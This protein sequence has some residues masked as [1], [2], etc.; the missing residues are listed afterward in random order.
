MTTSF[1]AVKRRSPNAPAGKQR[2]YWVEVQLVDEANVAVAG[3][4]W[5]LESHHPYDGHIEEFT[6]TGVSDTTGLIRVDMPY[7]LPLRLKLAAQPLADEMEKRALRPGRDAQEHSLV[8]Q[9][10]E[11]AG[12]VWHYAVIG[13]LCDDYPNIEKRDGEPFPPL[14]HFPAETALKGIDIQ[15]RDLEK[16]HVIEICPFRAWELVLHHQKGYSIANA[17]NLGGAACLAYADNNT[18]D[19]KS[20]PQFFINQC[21]DLSA[22]PV[23]YKSNYKNN[24]LVHDVPFSQRY[25]VP[26]FLDTGNAAE[27]EGDTRLFYV[28]NQQSIIVSWRGTASGTDGITDGTFRPIKSESCDTKMQC[29]DLLPA[30]KVHEGFWEAYSLAIRKFNDKID[31]V[32]QL[33]LDKDLFIAGHSLGGA[34]ALI[35]A[36]ELKAHNPLL[37]TYGMP[38]TFTR[39]ALLQLADIIH[40]RHV[41]DTD[42]VPGV[43]PEANVDN[44]FYDLWGPIGSTLGALWSTVE[45]SAYQ[46]VKWG[47]CYWHHGSPVIFLTATQSRMYRECKRTLPEPAGCITIK[48]A[49]PIKAKLYLVPELMLSDVQEAGEKQKVFIEK[50]TKDDVDKLI[51]VGGNPD[52]GLPVDFVN[53]FMTSYMP[54]INNKLLELIDAAKLSGDKRF[55]EHQDNIEKFKSQMAR[56][57]DEIPEDEFQRNEIF[58]TL[59]SMLY[60]SLAPTKV[61]VNGP[62]ALERFCIKA[63]EII[64]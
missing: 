17:I 44:A 27:P 6:H 46:V 12:Y 60:L 4:P 37:Y 16:R 15:T 36:I 23:F 20:I 52:R 21:Q 39:D 3:I 38:R 31:E 34:L 63:E 10:A 40:F 2:P 18:K 43:P 61:M 41:N 48:N 14:F 29:A 47:D 33:A 51:P 49:L 25:Q 19:I 32:K 50:L 54:Y 1:T 5:T 58:L 30:G 45:L 13:E 9:P 22:S 42:P 28:Y 59:E 53:H 56:N 64:E 35:H 57:K 55:A 24:S 26:V 62:A 8:R 7:G 11:D